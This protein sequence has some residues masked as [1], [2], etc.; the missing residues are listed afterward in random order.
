MATIT[1]KAIQAKPADTD[2]WLT[3][4]FKRGAGVF[5]ARI[6]PAAERLF[7]FR[8]TDSNGRRPFLPI[9]N[10]HPKGNNG[11][12]TLAAVTCPRSP[13]QSKFQKSGIARLTDPCIGLAV[14][15]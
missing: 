2:Q 8:Y 3:Q 11:G 9:G 13:Y 12:L 6:T 15:H 4:P 10:Y 7:Y 5:L 1:D 14:L